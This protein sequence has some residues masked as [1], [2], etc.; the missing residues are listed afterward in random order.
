M[1]AVCTPVYLDSWT[2]C[3]LFKPLGTRIVYDRETLLALK[4]SPLAKTPPRNMALIPGVTAPIDAN[5]LDGEDQQQDDQNSSED[6]PRE[7]AQ[8]T[9]FNM[10][11]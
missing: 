2:H 6:S 3:I 4:Q 5:V 1:R 8:D 10:E 7:P 9:T 11:L